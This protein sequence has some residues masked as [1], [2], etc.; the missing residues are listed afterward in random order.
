MEKGVFVKVLTCVS[1]GSGVAGDVR[2]G[3]CRILRGP[4]GV[5]AGCRL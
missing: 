5:P 1:K 3:R 4:R 2:L